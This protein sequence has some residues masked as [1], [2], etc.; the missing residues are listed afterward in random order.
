M[1]VCVCACCLTPFSLGLLFQRVQLTDLKIALVPLA[2]L[3][4]N[5]LFNSLWVG[6]APLH[7]TTRLSADG[8]S[9]ITECDCT[10]F[11][12]WSIISYTYHGV[13]LL[14]GVF[15]ASNT[16]SVPNGFNESRLL[17]VTLYNSLFC[18]LAIPILFAFSDNATAAFATKFV[19]IIYAMLFACVV[20]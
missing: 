16:A 12:L 10:D 17:A 11:T 3:L 2:A 5:L 13:I 18:A 1:C 20:S 6:L 14:Y 8:F 4:I 9:K 15:L 7:V 19:T